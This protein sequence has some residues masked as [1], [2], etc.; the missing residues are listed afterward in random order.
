MC[1]AGRNIRNGGSLTILATALIDRGGRLDDIVS[2]EFKG[3][4]NRKIQLPRKM[5]KRR[6]SPATHHTRSSPRR[7]DM[8]LT[9]E[10]LEGTYLIR[11]MLSREDPV[12]A[13]EELLELVM[14]TDNNAETIETL[15]RI[16]RSAEARRKK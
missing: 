11:R 9:Q 5:S 8:L 15:K 10:Q 7:E 4:A 6:F 12:Q 16:V 1:G 3:T 13:T 14:T 2:E